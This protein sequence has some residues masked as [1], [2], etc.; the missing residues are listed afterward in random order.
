[1]KIPIIVGSAVAY[2]L[3]LVAISGSQGLQQ[4]LAVLLGLGFT[5]T[6]LGGLGLILLE[7]LH[8][9]RPE[10]PAPAPSAAPRLRA[11]RAARR[12]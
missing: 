11:A 10:P 4:T 8:T 12:S 3:S 9:M 7:A 1:M 5:C 6:G 2:V